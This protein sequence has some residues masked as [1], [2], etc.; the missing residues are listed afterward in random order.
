MEKITQTPGLHHIAENIFINL[1]H[2]T[3]LECKKVNEFWR[4]IL[5]NPTFWI[6]ICAKNGLSLDNQMRWNTLIQ[7]LED[8]SLK[9]NVTEYLMEIHQGIILQKFQHPF[10]KAWEN[11]DLLLVEKYLEIVDSTVIEERNRVLMP[12]NSFD[13]PDKYVEMTPIQQAALEADY[14]ALKIFIQYSENPNAPDGSG[15]TPIQRIVNLYSRMK[16]GHLN[17]LR[18][19]APLANN[20]N[21]RDPKGWPL[22]ARAALDISQSSDDN[23]NMDILKILVPFSENPNALAFLPGAPYYHGQT[24]YQIVLQKRFNVEFIQLFLPFVENPNEPLS[25]CYLG[26]DWTPLQIAAYKG[27]E[28]AFELL[29]PFIGK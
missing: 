5:E 11:R 18:I 23:Y 17:V 19:L 14:E 13:Y 3:L 21:A 29:A 25:M 8:P 1:G 9:E 4:Q 10:Y 27:N 26:P 6:K 15:Y 7:E 24:P 16:S 2:E 20:P 22:I 12:N 28:A